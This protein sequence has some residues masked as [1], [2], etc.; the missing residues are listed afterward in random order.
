MKASVIGRGYLAAVHPAC[1]ANL[2]RAAVVGRRRSDALSVGE[3]PFFGRGLSEL[4]I[5][6]VPTP[7]A[8]VTRSARL[9]GFSKSSETLV[10]KPCRGRRLLFATEL[11]HRPDK[12]VARVRSMS[13]IGGPVEDDH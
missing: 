10:P 4:L 12:K 9:R 3:L 6:A 13:L 7:L 8:H 2:G 1:V 5:E 11:C